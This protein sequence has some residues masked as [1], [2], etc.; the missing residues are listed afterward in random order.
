LRGRGAYGA[1]GIATALFLLTSIVQAGDIPAAPIP[2]FTGNDGS[3]GWVE[4]THS[5]NRTNAVPVLAIPRKSIRRIKI[6]GE[7]VGGSA[8]AIAEGDDNAGDEKADIGNLLKQ[9]TSRMVR[10]GP[11]GVSF[12][13]AFNLVGDIRDAWEKGTSSKEKRDAVVRVLKHVPVEGEPVAANGDH[14]G[15]TA[16]P[17]PGNPAFP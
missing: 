6:S 10:E 16:G 5:G 1:V 14:G 11:E 13:G 4:I 17:P 3:K 12:G 15:R 7:A 9:Q 8:A 2:V